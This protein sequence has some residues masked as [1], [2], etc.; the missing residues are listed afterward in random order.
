MID[1]DKPIFAG[2]ELDPAFIDVADQI[3]RR[4]QA[5]DEIDVRDYV[6][7]YPQWACAILELLPTMHGL[8]AYGRAVDR[9]RLFA[10]QKG[11]PSDARIHKT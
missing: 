1:H 2:G 11:N 8:V 4:L 3:T 7:R 6:R 5:G 10:E 9:D